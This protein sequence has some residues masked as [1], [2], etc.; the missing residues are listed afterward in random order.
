MI[1]VFILAA[2]AGEDPIT[3]IGSRAPIAPANLSVPLSIIPGEEIE[4]LALSQLVDTLRLSPGVS[5]AR[6]GPTG[7]QTQVR[8]RGAE[9]NHTLVF[10][11]GIEVNDPA[12]S[13]EFRWETLAGNGHDKVEVLRGPQSAL[14]GAAALGGVVNIVTARPAPEE[15]ALLASAEAGSFATYRAAGR[16]SYG[17]GGG[18][19]TLGASYYDT[20]GIDGFAGGEIEKDGFESVNLRAKLLLA[21][22]DGGE[23]GLVGRYADS[24]TA[25]DGSDP[26]T[27]LRADT[28]DETEAE[29]AAVRAYARIAPFGPVW[30]HHIEGSWLTSTNRNMRGGAPLNRT[31]GARFRLLYQSELSASTGAL[32]HTLVLAAEYENEH[33]KSEDNAFFGFSDQRRERE[34]QSATGEY[35]VSS[36]VF[37]V[38]GSVRHDDN[39]GFADA[40]TWRVS[41]AVPLA[42]GLEA[43][44]GA[45]EG[46]A[47]PTFTEQFGFFPG[48]FVG[49]PELKPE[50][51]TGF[52]VGLRWRGEG[53]A[54]EAA[55]FR[56]DLKDEILTTFDSATFLSG[57]DNAAGESRRKG[58]ELAGEATLF[59]WLRARAAYTWLDAE[60]PPSAGTARVREVRRARH[61]A[62]AAL[63]AKWTGAEL[64]GMAN[65]VGPRR[66]IDFDV[67][68]AADVTLDD[69][70]LVNVSGAVDLAPGLSLT[71]R[72]QNLLGSDYRDVVGFET[73]GF[74][75]FAGLKIKWDG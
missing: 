36:S 52:E 14:W 66:D 19:L 62:S 22:I 17:F 7:G 71:G 47:V 48:S 57:V 64:T 10:V 50:R 11:D 2:V 15:T 27:F 74:A 41:G 20:E 63:F 25:F 40:T 56:T 12:S 45:G 68:P 4:A 54:L 18:G 33:F 43:F 37:R 55:Y 59:P 58:I 70:V 61:S 23:F 38:A 73:E 49:N 34:T 65:Y 1:E 30:T 8:L 72:V 24:R 39:E 32:M 51:S 42:G 75:I 28:D 46:F 67:F 6:A 60:E 31:E 13:N 16:L 53:A 44:A 21:P 5:I 35:R 3:V 26:A 69:Y 9:A 29:Q